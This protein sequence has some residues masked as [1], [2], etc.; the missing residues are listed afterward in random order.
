MNSTIKFIDEFF[1]IKEG[2]FLDL[3]IKGKL[4]ASSLE[5][6]ILGYGAGFQEPAPDIEFINDRIE[7]L[8]NFVDQVQNLLI[9]DDLPF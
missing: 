6:H 2:N 9:D 1:G 8:D 7:P 5:E 3:T 4:K